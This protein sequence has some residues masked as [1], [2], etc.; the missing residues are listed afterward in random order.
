MMKKENIKYLILFIFFF[1]IM[2]LSPICGDDWGNY[3]EGAKGFKHMIGN[4][5]G[6]YF[7]WEGR[8]VSRLL[9]NFLTYFKF[10]W[11]IVNS[12]VIVGTIYYIIKSINPKN[13]KMIF[14]SSCL[15]ML[16]MNIFTFSQVVVWLA[17]NITYLFVIPLML[18][19]FYSLFNNKYNKLLI[20]LNII[21]P[22]FV[23]H[24]GIILV[25]SNLFFIGLDYFKNKK[26]NKELILYLVISILSM[27]VM[28]ISPGSKG[29]SLVENIDFN[30]LS[31]FGKIIY[32]L[33]NFIYY[34]FFINTYLVVIMSISNFYLIKTIK[35]IVIRILG[36]IFMI[37]IPIIISF[38]YLISNFKY[39]NLD[40]SSLF[41]I[42]YFVVYMIIDLILII[43]TKDIKTIFFYLIGIGANAIMLLSPTWGYRTSLATYIFLSVSYLFIIDKNVKENKIINYI[44]SLV[45]CICFIL[46]LILYISVHRQYMDNFKLINQAKQNN[47]DVVEILAYP[48]FVNCNINPANDYHIKKFKLYYDIDEDKEIKLIDSKWKYIIFYQK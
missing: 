18:Y 3:L 7:S 1:I 24:T 8:F 19:Y 11:N 14:L 46:Y 26:L 37:P 12:L 25:L 34:T 39:I 42:V 38:M 4:A 47:A 13:K 48:G 6:M 15:I 17:G 28:L 32:N 29:R 20:F 30:N 31:L 21:I 10:I 45:I 16:L 43:K 22:M 23:E 44:L 35:N 36:Y 40:Q 33:P 5:I 27:G 41:I 9:I 2:C